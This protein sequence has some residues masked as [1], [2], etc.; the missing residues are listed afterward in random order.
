M[1]MLWK[2]IRIIFDPLPTIRKDFHHPFVL[3]MLYATQHHR[4]F[5]GRVP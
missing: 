4:R 1:L 3:K 2:E 5:P